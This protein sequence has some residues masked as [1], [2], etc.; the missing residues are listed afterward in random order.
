MNFLRYSTHFTSFSNLQ[1]L[2]EIQFCT[3]APG[4]KW[5][6]A[7]RPL[8]VGAAWLRPMPAN[9][10]APG[11]GGRGIRLCA[12]LGPGGGQSLGGGV[13]NMG[14]RRE[15]MAAAAAGGAAGARAHVQDKVPRG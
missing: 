8:A 10:G 7:M 6:L 3:D 12:H 9:R 5:G 1:I 11:R 14:A 2:L 4:N 13:T 15:Q